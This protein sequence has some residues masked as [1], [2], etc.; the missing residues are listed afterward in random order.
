MRERKSVRERQRERGSARED[1]RYG[2]TE[3]ER[4]Q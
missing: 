2:D 1:E 4:A 3:S